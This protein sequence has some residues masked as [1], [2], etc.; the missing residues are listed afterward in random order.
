ML[1]F[2]YG[3]SGKIVGDA[4]AYGILSVISNL[5]CLVPGSLDTCL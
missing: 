3:Y 2:L 4:R 5:A 1:C